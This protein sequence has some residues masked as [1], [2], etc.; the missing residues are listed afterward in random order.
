MAC[1][2]SVILW[3]PFIWQY[4][5]ALSARAHIKR[6]H[7]SAADDNVSGIKPKRGQYNYFLDE[8]TLPQP[9]I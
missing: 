5:I 3:S 9:R 4:F 6:G 8:T 2:V 7:S 1:C